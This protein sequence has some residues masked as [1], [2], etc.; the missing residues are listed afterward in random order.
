MNDTKKVSFD[1]KNFII[2]RKQ[3]IAGGTASIGHVHDMFE[4]YYM[5]SGECRYFIGNKVLPVNSNS[6]ILIPKGVQHKTRYMDGVCDRILLRMAGSYINPMLLPMIYRVF[7]NN[8]FVPSAKD[9]DKMLELFEKMMQEK[10]KND[11]YS[12]ELIK[13]YITELFSLI[14]RSH[15]EESESKHENGSIVID[16]AVEYMRKNFHEEITL[17]LMARR[18]AMSECRFSRIFKEVIGVGYKEYL[19]LIRVNEAN[20]YLLNTD[21]SVSEVAYACGFNDSN[22]FSTFFKKTNGMS[23]LEFRKLNSGDIPKK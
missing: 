8:V 16:D 22:Y 4:M 7:P 2:S 23:P 6:L 10:D 11:Y 17:T 1:D 20:K 19:N 15:T 14:L 3:Y 13:G 12:G 18:C 21:M 9:K 5:I